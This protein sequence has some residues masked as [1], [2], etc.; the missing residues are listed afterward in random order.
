MLRYSQLF[1][2]IDAENEAL[3]YICFF[4]SLCDKYMNIYVCICIWPNHLP[5]TFS[6]EQNFL[7]IR[8]RSI[9]LP[10]SNRIS[11]VFCVPLPN[12]SSSDL[13]SCTMCMAVWM[14]P[15]KPWGET[16]SVNPVLLGEAA[17]LLLWMVQ[18]STL[19]IWL[20]ILSPQKCDHPLLDPGW[21]DFGKFIH[22]ILHLNWFP[23]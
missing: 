15:S 8:G 20:N 9:Y 21:F 22:S 19:E 18:P 5:L 2:P 16:F 7:Q 4:N 10:N 12:W 17:F 11:V 14:M 6:T 1:C 23:G 3:L 13:F